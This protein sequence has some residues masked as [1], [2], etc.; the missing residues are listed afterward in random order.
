[1]RARSYP[2][3]VDV[4]DLIASFSRIL[5]DVVEHDTHDRLRPLS[6]ALAREVSY[7]RGGLI[8]QAAEE[9]VKEA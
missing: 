2:A 3:A 5:G 7:L 4:P 8:Q 6:A 9:P 1:M